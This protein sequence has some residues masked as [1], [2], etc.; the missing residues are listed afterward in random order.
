MY[1]LCDTNIDDQNH[2]YYRIE[3][4]GGKK[5]SDIDCDHLIS[6]NM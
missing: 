1:V 3:R 6:M 5:K 4:I 2:Y